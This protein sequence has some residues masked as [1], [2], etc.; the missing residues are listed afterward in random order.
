MKKH[1]IEKNS[2]M[3]L[4]ARKLQ[5]IQKLAVITDEAIL[6]IDSDNWK[7]SPEQKQFLEASI[8]DGR[9]G[10]TVSHTEAMHRIKTK[11]S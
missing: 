6:D 8:A 11:Y 2:T 4:E 5:L 10:N 1:Y 7:L 3:T 9:A